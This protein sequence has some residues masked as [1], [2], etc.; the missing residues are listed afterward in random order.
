MR[1]R[2]MPDLLS[3]P[4]TE[5]HCRCSRGRVALTGELDLATVAH[6]DVALRHAE[7]HGGDVVLDLRKVEFIDACGA[8]FIV[9]AA[10]R[11]R[12]N[13]ASLTVVRGSAEVGWLFALM[14]IDRALELVDDPPAAALPLQWT[15]DASGLGPDVALLRSPPGRADHR[16]ASA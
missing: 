13:G 10:R 1:G 9:E 7:A 5:L 15:A 3:A 12:L 4:R 8:Q 11:L 2:K 16:R 6:L 14:G